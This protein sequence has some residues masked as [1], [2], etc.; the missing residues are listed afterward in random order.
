MSET[1]SRVSPVVAIAAV[2]VI[3]FSAVGVGVMTGI[4]PS[5]FSKASEQ[6]GQA[7]P[8]AAKTATAP[9]PVEKKTAYK[10]ASAPKK[11]VTGPAQ[12][13]SAE[14]A[15]AAARVCA[16]CG[17]VSA[18]NIVEQEGE[19]SGLGA[20]AGGVAG[21]VLG[22]QVGR[23]TGRKVATVAGAAG[24]AYAGYQIEKQMKKTQRYDVA[25]RLEDG[26][27]RIFSYQDQPAFRP[28]DKVKVV[29]GALVAN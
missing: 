24:G 27:S 12:V 20:I 13:A 8:E 6:Q 7:A 9:A 3:V 28:G 21:A 10:T 16:N 23:G 25:V 1:R 11:T 15:R 5:S 19:A 18:V 17:T 4:I 2:S 22:N 26:T 14:P 29:D